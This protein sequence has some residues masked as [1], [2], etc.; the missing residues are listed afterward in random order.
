[1]EH[2]NLFSVTFILIIFSCST[3]DSKDNQNNIAKTQFEQTIE[4]YN[5][6][7]VCDCNDDGIKTLQKILNIRK[8][9]STYEL[10]QKDSESINSIELLKKEWDLIRDSCI[11][12]FAA[13]LFIP[14]DCNEPDKIGSLRDKLNKLNIR[15]S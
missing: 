1:M 9:Y 4:K 14:S 3:K 7:S 6:I 15:T 11:K 12:K 2:Y 8:S 13:K 10:Y 5:P